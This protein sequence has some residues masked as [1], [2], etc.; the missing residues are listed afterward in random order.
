MM[1]FSDKEPGDWGPRRVSKE[2]VIGSFSTLF[3]INYIKDAAFESLTSDGGA[4]A[5]LVSANKK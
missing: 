4:K 2:E 5:Y 3:K 1:C